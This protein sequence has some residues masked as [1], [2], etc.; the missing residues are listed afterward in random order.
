MVKIINLQDCPVK[1]IRSCFPNQKG[2]ILFN[3]TYFYM[4][5][6]QKVI[7]V[8][9]PKESA[10]LQNESEVMTWFQNGTRALHYF[11]NE[12]S[13]ISGERKRWYPNGEICERSF[14]NNGLLLELDKW[15]IN[16]EHSY[17]FS[18]DEY[19]DSLEKS[20]RIS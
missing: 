15:F 6:N 1:F 17:H 10:L 4:I 7:A 20:E 11:I 16:G 18:L 5:I 13:F 8:V 12:E 3:R 2:D 14:Y 19:N 9:P